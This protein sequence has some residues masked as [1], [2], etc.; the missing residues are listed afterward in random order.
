VRAGEQDRRAG[1]REAALERREKAVEVKESGQLL[2]AQKNRAI[3]KAADDRDQR[4]DERDVAADARD[5]A[6]SL[7]SFL[8]D[9]DYTPGH[10]SR[11]SAGLDRQDSKATGPGR[12]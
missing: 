7:E 8:V 2:R 5:R 1:L 6:A 11:M 12:R 3:L 9:A 10:K 4:A